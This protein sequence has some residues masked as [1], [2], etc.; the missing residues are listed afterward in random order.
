[1]TMAGRGRFLAVFFHEST[2]LQDG[3]QKLGYE[4]SD[5]V[6]NSVVSKGAVSCISRGSFLSWVG[7]SNDSSLLAMDSDGMLAML[8]RPSG[9][10]NVGSVNGWR[11]KP[12][13]DTVGLRKSADDS[14]WPVTAY[15]GKLVCVPLK[16]GTKHPDATRRPVTA[17]LDF[18]PLHETLTRA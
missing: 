7:F 9:A 10:D 16:G 2:P 4:L 1:V 13:L 8:V 5:A 12:M 14:Y 11:W 18:G 17:A 6:A 15:D 3:T